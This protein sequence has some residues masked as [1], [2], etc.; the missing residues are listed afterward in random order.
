M[1]KAGVKPAKSS[2]K[3]DVGAELL[4]S[5][6]EMKAGARA[7]VHTPD[8]PEFVHAR[9]VSGLSQAEFAALLGV[10]VRTL[11]DWEQG[12]RKPSGA[13]ITLY[14]IAERRPEVLRELAA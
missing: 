12:R 5:V 11:Q 2:T 14:K 9:L 6:R 13:A 4:A 7:R 10:S 1:P 3:I 8:V